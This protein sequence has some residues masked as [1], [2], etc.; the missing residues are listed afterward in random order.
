MKTKI[1]IAVLVIVIIAAGVLLGLKYLGN[2]N[3]QIATNN[4]EE[5]SVL[6]V[7][8]KEKKP[9]PKSIYEGNQRTLAVM[10]DNVGDAVPQTGLNKAMLVYEVYVEGG[11]TRY[12][13][14]FQ[15]VDIDTIGPVRS[16]RPVFID[17][18]L[19][20]D[21]IYV[22]FGGSDRALD[23]VKKLKMENVS[24]LVTPSGVFWRT[25]KKKAPHNAL[26]STENIWNY[27]EKREYRTTTE[28]RNVLNY[29]VKPIDLEDGE[30]AI[31]VEIPYKNSKIKYV[32]NEEKGIYERYEKN[33]IRTDWLTGE[34][35]TTKNII[36]TFANN[37]TT[38][39][40]NGY[41]RQEIENIGVKDGYYITNGKA[42]KITCEKTARAA[43]TVYKDLD[44][45]EI[46]VNDGNTWIQIVPPSMNITFKAPEVEEI[47]D[48]NVVQEN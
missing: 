32:Y 33:K 19:E 17:Y 6:N 28:E 3:G 47:P 4:V 16:A 34:T 5:N 20:N 44:G 30:G 1:L 25:N 37:Y 24:G 9:E 39:E 26:I 31:E 22:H 36:I 48:A 29:S 18:A 43:K 41:G 12:M 27:A 38:S 46:K 8:L 2:E 7:T 45:N 10:I 23:D 15:N 42:I 35:L 21:S 14:V 13:T 11:L 40:E